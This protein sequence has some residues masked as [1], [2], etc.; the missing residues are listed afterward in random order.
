MRYKI[1]RSRYIPRVPNFYVLRNR[2]RNKLNHSVPF[3]L[4]WAPEFTI[5]NETANCH[6]P[7][8]WWPQRQG[9]PS[10]L[11]LE[12]PIARAPVG[13]VWAWLFPFGVAATSVVCAK[14]T[15]VNRC[16]YRRT[17]CVIISIRPRNFSL[18]KKKKGARAE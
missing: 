9:S 5:K 4:V 8:H 11:N 2:P 6:G 13:N 10:Q 16:A 14:T 3:R 12:R 17:S 18:N 15:P 1:S 7:T